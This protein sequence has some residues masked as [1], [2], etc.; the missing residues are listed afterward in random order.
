MTAAE[1][2]KELSFLGNESTKRVLMNHG[3][4]EPFYGVKVEDLK[5]IQKRVKVDHRLALELYDTG[6]S[7][8]MYLA[9]LIADDAKMSKQDLQRWLDQAYWYMLSEYTVPWVAT[10]SPHGR[11]LARKWVDGK[12]EAVAAAGW[13]T[14]AG[15]VLTRPDEKLDLAELKALLKRVATTIHDQPN[16]VRHTMN[17]FVIAVGGAV[18]P[19]ADLAIATGEKVG[20][21]SVDMGK[22]ACKVPFAPDCIRKIHDRGNLGRKRKTM[23]C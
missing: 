17:G 1:I 7:D 19:L 14:L 15:L 18:A 4:R 20:K 13:C 11:E 22:T 9:G 8:A 10:G 2:V 12:K 16:R 5:K 6:I 23:K 3:A 21:V